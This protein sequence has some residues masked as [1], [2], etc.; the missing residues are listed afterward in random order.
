MSPTHD[1]GLSSV[2]E[3]TGVVSANSMETCVA[4]KALPMSAI[5]YSDRGR[6][7]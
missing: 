1:R 2:Y 6:Q 4:G 3:A 5:G 7:S